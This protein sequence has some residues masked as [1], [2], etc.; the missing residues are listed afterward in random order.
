MSNLIKLALSESEVNTILDNLGCIREYK[1]YINED[2]K[3]NRS[4]YIVKD[5]EGWF[6]YNF[7]WSEFTHEKLK[8]TNNLLYVDSYIGTGACVN[9]S[10]SLLEVYWLTSANVLV[11]DK[12]LEILADANTYHGLTALLSVQIPDDLINLNKNEVVN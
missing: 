4:K 1:D 3:A 2:L 11:K 12:P 7:K 8:F 9:S 10:M 6:F 5:R